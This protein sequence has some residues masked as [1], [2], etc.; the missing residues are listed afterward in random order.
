MEKSY[1]PVTEGLR[2]EM[3]NFA[4]SIALTRGYFAMM[5]F[6]HLGI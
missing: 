4:T 6:C 2:G 3:G 1:L 5:L